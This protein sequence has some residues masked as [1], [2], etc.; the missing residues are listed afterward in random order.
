MQRLTVLVP[1]RRARQG[2]LRGCQSRQQDVRSGSVL[3]V[4]AV[5]KQSPARRGPPHESP[6]APVPCTAATRAT[7]GCRAQRLLGASQRTYARQQPASA[8]AARRLFESAS[9]TCHMGR[10]RLVYATP[11]NRQPPRVVGLSTPQRDQRLFAPS[12]C[13]HRRSLQSPPNGH[14]TGWCTHWMPP[15]GR[16][17]FSRGSRRHREHLGTLA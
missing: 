8:N 2:L 5:E 13:H 12:G 6:M 9:M 17:S 14:R 15:A 11:D 1:R 4:R 3:R 10:E 7:A 16:L